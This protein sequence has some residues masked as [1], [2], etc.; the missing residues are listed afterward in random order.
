MRR[1]A[2]LGRD[3]FAARRNWPCVLR[4][5]EAGTHAIGENRRRYDD[6][7]PQH[8]SG[9]RAREV[10]FPAMSQWMRQSGE[11]RPA[12][13]LPPALLIRDRSA[14]PGLFLPEGRGTV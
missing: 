6:P 5:T 13:G 7:E 3:R 8:P 1:A 4:C 14:D 2:A 10:A 12:R 9:T 11:R